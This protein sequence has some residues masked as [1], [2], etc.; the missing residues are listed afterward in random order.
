LDYGLSINFYFPETL[1]DFFECD[2]TIASWI[3][4]IGTSAW[5]SSREDMMLIMTEEP[6]EK[7]TAVS[8]WA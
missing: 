8:H 7:R 4:C 3:A 6:R 1:N 5:N 2:P